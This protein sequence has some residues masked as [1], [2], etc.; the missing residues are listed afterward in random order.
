MS[1]KSMENMEALLKTLKELKQ[2]EFRNKGEDQ[3]Q[4]NGNIIDD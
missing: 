4:D 2:A 3:A 1:D